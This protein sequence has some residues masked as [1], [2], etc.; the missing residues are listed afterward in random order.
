MDTLIAPAEAPVQA[1]PPTSNR[2]A[3]I[4][5]HGTLDLA[6]PPLILATAAA[7]MDME[8]TIFFT[9]YGLDIIKKGA[10]RQAP[11]SARRQPRHACAR[12]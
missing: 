10:D 1:P 2:L 12:A 3:I 4:A 9:F 5:M 7:A 11:G 6:Y 8:V